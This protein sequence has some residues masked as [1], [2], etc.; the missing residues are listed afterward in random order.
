MTFLSLHLQAINPDLNIARSYHLRMGKDLLGEFM[1]KI[2]YGRIGHKP[3]QKVFSF[4]S[5][6]ECLQRTR[7]YLKKRSTAYKR[8]GCSYEVIHLEHDFSLNR[9]DILSWLTPPFEDALMFQRKKEQSSQN[10]QGIL[11][12][13]KHGKKKTPLKESPF[14]PLFDSDSS[15]LNPPL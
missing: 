3:S 14:L 13:E 8:I 4:T 12:V 2:S 7:H 11:I 9:E 10:E 15:F 1:L 6:Q 5:Q